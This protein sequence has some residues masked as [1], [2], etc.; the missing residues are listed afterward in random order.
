M[1]ITNLIDKEIELIYPDDYLGLVPNDTL[2]TILK[3]HNL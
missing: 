1:D 3:Y 2:K